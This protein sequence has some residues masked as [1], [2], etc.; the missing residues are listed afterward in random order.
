M[1]WSPW[2]LPILAFVSALTGAALGLWGNRRLT[3][4]QA[5]KATAEAG[6]ASASARHTDAETTRVVVELYQKAFDDMKERLTV[7][8][9]SQVLRASTHAE[10]IASLNSRISDLE[11][12][13]VALRNEISI[14]FGNV[15]TLND[16]IAGLETLVKEQQQTIFDLKDEIGVLVKQIR[17]LGA[18]PEK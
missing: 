8:E 2:V 15:G 4:A 9:D 12:T 18:E 5:H 7:I 11:G 16:R 3:A 13:I 14:H 6:A 17:G 10:L 1:D